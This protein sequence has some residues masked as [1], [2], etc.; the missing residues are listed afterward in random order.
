MRLSTEKDSISEYCIGQERLQKNEFHTEL[1]MLVWWLC[2]FVCLF[3]NVIKVDLGQKGQISCHLF[4]SCQRIRWAHS[5]IW[6]GTFWWNCWERANK[7][8][9]CPLP[10]STLT[11]TELTRFSTFTLYLPLAAECFYFSL[12]TWTKIL[13]DTSYQTFLQ[14]QVKL[15]Q[16]WPPHVLHFENMQKQLLHRYEHA[17]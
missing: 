5:K 7:Q 14:K 6:R 10:S 16:S 11:S 15:Y 3:W 9:Q 17:T 2:F 4:S 8:G 1:N 13:N 12:K